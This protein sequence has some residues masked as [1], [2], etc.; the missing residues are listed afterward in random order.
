MTL[1]QATEAEIQQALYNCYTSDYAGFIAIVH[2][3]RYGVFPFD[4]QLN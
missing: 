4:P 2:F 3:N 1:E